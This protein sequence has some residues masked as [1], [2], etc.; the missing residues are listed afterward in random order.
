MIVHTSSRF[1][2][3]PL[4]V[5]VLVSI[6]HGV[7]DVPTLKRRA[8]FKVAGEPFDQMIEA[9]ILRGF[10]H[11]GRGA[12]LYL[13]ERGRSELPQVASVDMGVYRPA[14]APPRRPGSDHSHI[15]SVAGGRR[16]DY[17]PHC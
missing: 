12:L 15:P 11:R 5:C 2:L 7:H 8:N 9:L 4:H 3:G 6:S 14:P 13:T 10:V 17:R 1:G 16:Y